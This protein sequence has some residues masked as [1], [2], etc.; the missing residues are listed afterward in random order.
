MRLQ[1][2]KTGKGLLGSPG[3]SIKGQ[4][5]WEERTKVL[6]I[7]KIIT[8]VRLCTWSF[9]SFSLFVFNFFQNFNMF[10]LLILK[11]TLLH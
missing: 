9:S 8:K 5:A 10:S 7:I 4:P 3:K 6:I 11:S 1:Y 2:K